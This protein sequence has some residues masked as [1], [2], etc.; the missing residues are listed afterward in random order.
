[1][2]PATSHLLS[3]Q[4][5]ISSVSIQCLFLSK[6]PY[7]PAST[8]TLLRRQGTLCSQ[9]LLCSPVPQRSIHQQRSTSG[10]QPP[11][12]HRLTLVWSSPTASRKL[13]HLL[14]LPPTCVLLPIRMRCLGFFCYL[15]CRF[16]PQL[17]ASGA[18]A[19]YDPMAE[20]IDRGREDGVNEG[21][22][23][24]ELFRRTNLR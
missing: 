10:L 18:I 1:M 7:I 11:V 6:I 21:R 3:F 12:L 24:T 23:S 13:L 5:R 22:E 4:A 19:G 16:L 9:A 2:L 17:K 20:R 14:W 8:W 15:C